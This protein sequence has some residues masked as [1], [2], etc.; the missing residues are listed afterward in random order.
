MLPYADD[1]RDLDLVMEAAGIAKDENAKPICEQ[2][3]K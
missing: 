1:I 3:T 2:L